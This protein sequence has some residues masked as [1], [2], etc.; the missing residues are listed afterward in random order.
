[1]SFSAYFNLYRKTE[2]LSSA[3]FLVCNTIAES[4]ELIAKIKNL[5]LDLI[6][7]GSLIK[8]NS[9]GERM[10]LLFKMEAALREMASLM[11]IASISGLVSEMNASILK[12]EF[13]VLNQNL[14]E[15]RNMYGKNTIS[16]DYFKQEDDLLLSSRDTETTFNAVETN[17]GLRINGSILEPSKNRGVV[18]DR[19]SRQEH[20]E[21]AILELIK[22]KGSV[23]IKDIS[24]SIKGCSEKTI[25]RK[26]IALIKSGV[27][28]KEGERRWSRYSLI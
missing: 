23:N 1:M 4:G 19:N 25:Q 12:Q 28:K 14:A 7:Y 27:I 24:K 8:D 10:K 15:V 17:K 2:R 22:A 9:A 16:N 21:R 13:G 11:D 18:K 3:V 5:A 20:R 26:L 6:T